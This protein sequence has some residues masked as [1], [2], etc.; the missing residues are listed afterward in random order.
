MNDIERLSGTLDAAIGRLAQASTFA[1]ARHQSPVLDVSRRILRLEGGLDLLLDRAADL[2]RAGLFAGSVWDTPNSLLPQLVGPSLDGEDPALFALESISLLRFLSVATGLRSNDNL[3]IHQAHHFLS[4]TLALN[5]RK[6][7]RFSDEA[8]RELGEHSQIAERLL[9]FIAT[10]IGLRDV[11]GVLVSEIWRI[12]EQRPVQTG[13]VK[14]MITQIA[15]ALNQ[16]GSEPGA[17]RLGAERLIGALF[18]PTTE[19]MADPGVDA[20]LERLSQMDEAGLS[21]EALGFARAMQD[22]GLVSDYHVTFILWAL[23]YPDRPF[24]PEA[25]G[26]SLTGQNCWRQFRGLVELLIRKGVTLA[27]PQAVYGLAMML[28]RGILHH[29]PLAPGLQRVLGLHL[30]PEVRQ[31]FDLAFGTAA[32]AETHL[33]AALLQILGQPLG[34]GQ[35]ANPTCQSA[36]AISMWAISDP[37]FIMHLVVQ[38]AETGAIRMKFEGQEIDSTN[39]PAGL[40]GYG[41][42]DADAV[43]VLLVPHLDRIYAEMGRLC[44]GREGDPHRWINPEFHGWWVAPGCAVAVDVTTGRLD[45]YDRFVAQFFASY[46]PDF[47]DGA[48]LIHPQPAGIAYTDTTGRF[49]GWHAITILRVAE[50]RHG[51]MRVYF[52]NPNNDS[53]QDWGNGVQ[54]T[55]SGNGE[56][57][58]EGSL[59]FEQFLSRLYL[60]HYQPTISHE[61]S[62]LGEDVQARVLEMA[63]GSWAAD[64]MAAG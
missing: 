15:L 2:D 9:K 16:Q 55:T 50:G 36:R 7:F 23:D 33:L 60:F 41:P 14:E 47:N 8:S 17:E 10:R 63:G 53:G 51:E 48:N 34:V 19:T 42:I 13:T 38:A 6:F 54:V 18:G 49:V 5:L 35:G 22:T 27:S 20:Y 4:Q 58:G 11:L 59:E 30:L 21:R 28:E 29:S 61:Q 31:R 25:L 56:R 37:D 45:G 43:S 62:K 32:P 26:L 40:A 46:H 52:F 24:V 57:P 3:Q 12:L 1:K 44:L 39:L 64:R